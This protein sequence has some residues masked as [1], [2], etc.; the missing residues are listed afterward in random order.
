MVCPLTCDRNILPEGSN[1]M[2]LN[3]SERRKGI[4]Q[5]LNSAKEPVKGADLAAKFDVSRQ[6]IVQDIA[7][8]RAAGKDILATPRGYI[9]PDSRQPSFL[10]KTLV[11]KHHTYYE[12]EDELTTIVDLGG[13]IIDVI[14]EHPIYGEKRGLL[15]ISSRLD[16]ED[17]MTSLKRDKAAP[18]STLTGGIHLHTVEVRDEATFKRIRDALDKKGY[19]IKE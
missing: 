10:K 9:I 18:L 17:F 14:I 19:L 12:I 2:N 13:K 6:V 4:F 11:C 16:V 7:V 5:V 1:P 3:S 15:M 8:L